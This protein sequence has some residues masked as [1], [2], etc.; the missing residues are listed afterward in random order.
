MQLIWFGLGNMAV[1]KPAI[2]CDWWLGG[3]F[4]Q[5][6]SGQMKMSQR[7]SDGIKGCDISTKRQLRVALTGTTSGCKIP[8]V[9]CQPNAELLFFC[10]WHI[11]VHHSS[12][13]YPAETDVA[14]IDR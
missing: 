9:V 14:V 13:A 4:R 1:S 8:E 5:I 7:T 6:T 2:V 12:N 11:Q 10:C 3:E